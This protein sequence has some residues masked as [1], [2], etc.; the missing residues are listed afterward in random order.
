[1][2]APATGPG[3]LKQSSQTPAIAARTKPS[4][5]WRWAGLEPLSCTHTS[6]APA[7]P[8]AEPG[9]AVVRRALE[10]P[11]RSWS[12]PWMGCGREG[13]EGWRSWWPRVVCSEAEGSRLL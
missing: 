10:G 13:Q 8:G 2:P 11:G 3:E 4:T 7:A 6:A 1:M 9:Q 12:S 5:A